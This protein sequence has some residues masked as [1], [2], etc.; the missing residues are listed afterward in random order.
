M[1]FSS[2]VLLDI[3]RVTMRWCNKSRMLPNLIKTLNNKRRIQNVKG[4]MTKMS[5]RDTMMRVDS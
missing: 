3:L 1:V 4:S 2:V 5:A